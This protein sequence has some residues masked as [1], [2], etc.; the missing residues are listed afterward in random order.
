MEEKIKKTNGCG[1]EKNTY[2]ILNFFK[3]INT[4]REI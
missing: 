3:K 2:C 1:E 4:L